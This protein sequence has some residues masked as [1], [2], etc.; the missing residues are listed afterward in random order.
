MLILIKILLKCFHGLLR[1]MSTHSILSKRIHSE[2]LNKTSV[3][4]N[5][6]LIYVNSYFLFQVKLY[7]LNH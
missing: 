4:E 1:D 6:G 7:L 3:I 2:G 5:T